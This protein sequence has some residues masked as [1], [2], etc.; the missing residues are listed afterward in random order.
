MYIIK[1]FENSLT[2]N[3]IYGRFSEGRN[4]IKISAYSIVEP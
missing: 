3:Q 4:D 1:M 2:K